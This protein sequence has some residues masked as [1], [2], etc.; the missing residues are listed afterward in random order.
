MNRFARSVF[1]SAAGMA[2]LGSALAA[3]EPSLPPAAA[4]SVLVQVDATKTLHR[5][6]ES[7]YHGMNFVALWNDTG[8]A[9]GAVKA[10]AQMDM[11]LV[12]FPGGC[13]C[14]W[15]DWQEP[16]A[17]GW[18]VLTPLRAWEFAKAGKARMVF[19]TNVANDGGGSNKTTHLPYR[20]NSSG[21]HAADWVRFCRE[22]GIDV[23]F[24]EIGNE[25][26]MDAPKQF[27]NNQ[28]KVYQWYN[29][30]YAEQAKAIR[31]ADPKARIMGPAACNTWFWW[32]EHNLKKFLKAHGN[33]QGSGLA[34][35]I[36][37]HWY[38]EGGAGAWE[39]KRGAAQQWVGCMNYIRGAIQEFD[40]RD[41][42]LYI[43]EWNW[44]AGDKNDGAQK[45]SNAL[46]S[47]DV[48]GM[49]LRTGVA[50]H[51]FFC[52]QKIKRGWGVL[53]MK[54]DCRPQND[55]AP[56]YYALRMA[57]LLSGDVL[58]TTNSVDE[59]NTLSAYAARRSDGSVRVLLINKSAER[60]AVA[61][62]FA[63]YSPA[64]K[65]VL[66]YD[67]AGT[68]ASAEDTEVV[69]N[70]VTSP[71]PGE[72]S[73]PPPRTVRPNGAV[74]TQEMRPYSMAVLVIGASASTSPGGRAGM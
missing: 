38:P 19:Q 40:T 49:F 65:P 12:R 67:L 5:V 34:D 30:K 56:T 53:A 60:L 29:E 24:W 51:T 68:G 18:T 46:G 9:P 44:G 47:A 55:A 62:S 43:T 69:Y 25:P 57:A 31:Q 48:V 70:G 3:D 39:K 16:L 71:N 59:K 54:Q 6:S 17:T 37:L 10:F 13:P 23:A 61:L 45:V 21:A 58:A 35:A 63:G 28:D 7:E 26:E 73:L 22:K 74:L 41:L 50:G 72:E 33:K 20:F 36:S 1:L 66:I 64:D 15:Y 42:P 4:Q 32:H 52:L 8:D 2:L 11:R 14:E 27:K